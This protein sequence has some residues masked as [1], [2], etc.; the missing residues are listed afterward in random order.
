MHTPYHPDH[1]GLGFFGQAP[2]DPSVAYSMHQQPQEDM[3]GYYG[4]PPPPPQPKSP[5]EPPSPAANQQPHLAAESNTPAL[6]GGVAGNQT[7][8]KYDPSKTPRSPYWGHL[9][10][11]IAMGLS[12]PQTHAKQ[13]NVG[14][15]S[16]QEG[17]EAA[18]LGNAQPLLLRQSQFYGYGPAHNYGPPSPATQFMMSPQA[19]FAFNYGYG[20][21]PNQGHLP[22][23][24]ER[25]PVG[26]GMHGQGKNLSSSLQQAAP[27]P[28]SKRASKADDRE[29]P[30][31]V[32][33]I[34]ETE[35]LTESTW[36]S[37]IDTNLNTPSKKLQA[38]KK[39]MQRIYGETDPQRLLTLSLQETELA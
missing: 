37:A 6:I 2:V 12:T 3:N 11:T 23:H 10:S 28:R 26:G 17:A 22:P 39:L 38:F 20:Y 5:Q 29:S 15:M 32:E 34:T 21:S 31:T 35:S 25:S 13:G 19:N 1:A 16:P 36:A 7:P 14:L 8:Y 24:C 18:H 30:S 9:D 33:T 27:G 4:I